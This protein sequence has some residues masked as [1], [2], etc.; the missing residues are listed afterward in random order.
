[1]KLVFAYGKESTKVTNLFNHFQSLWSE[2]S[3]VMRKNKLE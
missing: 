2:I 1:M 3:E